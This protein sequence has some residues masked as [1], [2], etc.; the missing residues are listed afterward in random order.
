MTVVDNTYAVDSIGG[1]VGNY[2]SFYESGLNIYNS[3]AKVNFAV[4][5]NDH[6]GLVGTHFA[7]NIMR[8]FFYSKYMRTLKNTLSMMVHA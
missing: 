4:D 7:T 8:L 1:I 5:G 2:Y 3:K 6:G